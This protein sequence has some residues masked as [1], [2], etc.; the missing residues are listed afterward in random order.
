MEIQLTTKAEEFIA[1]LDKTD[2]AKVLHTVDLLEKFGNRLQLP[3]SKP[4][5]N[6]LFEL[7]IRGN[8]EIRIFYGYHN[9]KAALLHGIVKKSRRIPRQEFN[10]AL[11][12]LKDLT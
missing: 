2:I 9:N 6:G 11:R 4:V 5:G 7:R 10:T 1:S 3:H 12:E 8:K